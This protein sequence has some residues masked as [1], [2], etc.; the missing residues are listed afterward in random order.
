MCFVGTEASPR[1][2]RPHTWLLA[3]G[4]RYRRDDG[5]GPFVVEAVARAVAGRGGVHCS[6]EPEEHLDLLIEGGDVS[7]MVLVD[8]T[9]ERLPRGVRV[10]RLEPGPACPSGGFHDLTPE[11][12][13]NLAHLLLSATP[14]C[15]LV[16]IQGDD[17]GHG[18][19]LSPAARDRAERVASTLT[20]FAAKEEQPWA[21][22][23]IF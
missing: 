3:W 10:C 18:L 11:G 19:G 7:A 2:E 5:L 21:L 22:D 16:A 9:V 1:P 15:W 13:A 20:M 8:A 23:R 17:F 4:N 12:F 6:P 14:A